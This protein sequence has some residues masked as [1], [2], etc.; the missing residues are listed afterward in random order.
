MP[1]C[2]ELYSEYK[3][4]I[5]EGTPNGYEAAKW[6]K[7]DIEKNHPDCYRSKFLHYPPPPGAPA[8][9]RVL[10]KEGNRLHGGP[11]CIVNAQSGRVLGLND[12]KT[13]DNGSAV[14]LSHYTGSPAQQWLL[15]E[16]SSQEWESRP[17]HDV[18]DSGLFRI[19]NVKACR[20][21]DAENAHRAENGCKIHVWDRGTEARIRI[22]RPFPN[23]QQVWW[24]HESGDCKY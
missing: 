12:P 7:L 3:R 21:L 17:F 23:I 2:E 8:P 19:V 10:G 13:T 24:I 20:V 9:I 11:F 5:A 18:K 15:E 1:T 6:I 22:L 14:T 4:Q 16:V